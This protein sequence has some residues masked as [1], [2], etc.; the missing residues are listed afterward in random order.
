RLTLIIQQTRFIGTPLSPIN[1]PRP[2]RVL[3]QKALLHR[4]CRPR[5]CPQ[6]PQAAPIIARKKRR[7]RIQRNGHPQSPPPT[8]LTKARKKLIAN[9]STPS[10]TTQDDPQADELPTTWPP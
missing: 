1:N 8:P 9:A 2:Q 6:F 4:I 10:A 5:Q 3:H 7:I